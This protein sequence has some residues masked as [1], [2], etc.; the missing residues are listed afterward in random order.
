MYEEMGPYSLVN[1]SGTIEMKYRNT[2]W[3]NLGHILFVDQPLGV[4]FSVTNSSKPVTSSEEAAEDFFNFIDAFYGVYPELST[5]GL[6]I[7]GESYAGHY[8]PVFT[9]RLLENMPS[10]NTVWAIAIGDGWTDP[11]RQQL[12][13]V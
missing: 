8:I 3:N 4:G 1:K 11:G 7:T 13:Y 6:I 2:T 5:N 10:Y 12:T 9:K